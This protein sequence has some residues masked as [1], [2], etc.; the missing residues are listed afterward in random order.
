MRFLIDAQR[1]PVSGR[2]T[3]APGHAAEPA[4][5]RARRQNGTR[6]SCVT[7]DGACRS[8]E[9]TGILALQL[10]SNCA[11]LLRHRFQAISFDRGV[12][13]PLVFA[14]AARAGTLASGVV[15]WATTSL[16]DETLFYR[17]L[18]SFALIERV[19]M[20]FALACPRMDLIRSL[21]A[22]AVCRGRPCR[23]MRPQEYR[24]GNARQTEFSAAQLRRERA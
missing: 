12:I 5:V 21:A 15:T 7:R 18:C 9:E 4:R 22:S 17:L 24:C 6:R 14:A 10:Q 23:H 19:F 3:V 16:D 2:R 1:P 11:V 8:A 13:T 20:D